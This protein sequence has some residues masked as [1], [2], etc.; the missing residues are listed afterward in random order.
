MGY[1]LPGLARGGLQATEPRSVSITYNFE[2][3][4]DVGGWYISMKSLTQ[5]SNCLTLEGSFSSVSTATTARKDAFC[6]IFSNLQD[7][8]SFAPLRPE[9]FS[10][11]SE[12]V[13]Q[14]LD[15]S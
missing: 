14:K 15:K 9:K 13:R 11:I 1:R 10:N 12:K 2:L 6:C 7:L 4:L 3:L 8:N 5:L